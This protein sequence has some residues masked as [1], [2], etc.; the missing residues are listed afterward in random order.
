[1]VGNQPLA[2]AF[3]PIFRNFEQL[4]K[5]RNGPRA[6]ETGLVI[7]EKNGAVFAISFEKAQSLKSPNHT[8]DSQVLIFAVLRQ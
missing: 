4:Q 6:L 1:M 5:P 3:G 7:I 2:G 8:D